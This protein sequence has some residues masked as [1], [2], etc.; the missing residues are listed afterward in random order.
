MVWMNGHS[1]RLELGNTIALQAD[2]AHRFRTCFPPWEHVDTCSYASI[3]STA[4]LA[5]ETTIEGRFESDGNINE[6][7]A[8]VIVRRRWRNGGIERH[9][10]ML[11]L[12]PNGCPRWVGHS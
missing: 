11:V 7:T 12:S 4:K 6:N 3:T 5:S 8:Q 1:T 9:R 10:A 2:S